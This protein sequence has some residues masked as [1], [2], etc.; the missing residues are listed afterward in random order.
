MTSN[1]GSMYSD[2]HA[3]LRRWNFMDALIGALSV[4]QVIAS[5]DAGPNWAPLESSS[6]WRCVKRRHGELRVYLQE[7]RVAALGAGRE[8][9]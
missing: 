1:S 7:L 3:K 5:R 6:A 8:D 4:C 9:R 2:D